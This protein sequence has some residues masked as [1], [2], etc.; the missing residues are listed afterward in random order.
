M[1]K[2]RKKYNPLKQVEQIARAG[3]NEMVITF[4]SLDDKCKVL[5]VKRNRFYDP[6]SPNMFKAIWEIRHYW[7]LYLALRVKQS[8][9]KEGYVFRVMEPP[10]FPVF[11]PEI[12]ESLT[13]Q[14][15]EFAA[16]EEGKGNT[17]LNAGWIADP[18][19]KNVFSDEQTDKILVNLGL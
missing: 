12:E 6:I 9:G 14:H 1:A 16:E 17:I 13:A 19:G 8:N 7:R 5:D 2:K 3:L 18:F 4:N 15:K 11:Q 10:E